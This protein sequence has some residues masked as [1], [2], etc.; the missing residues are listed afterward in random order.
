MGIGDAAALADAIAAAA[1]AGGDIGSEAALR[2]YATAQYARNT[3][4]L[5]GLDAVKRLFQSDIA[6]TPLHHWP[7][8]RGLGLHAVN[9]MTPLK[10]ALASIAMGEDAGAGLPGLRDL[11]GGRTPMSPP[12]PVA[13][14]SSVV[15]AVQQAGR[16]AA[17][18]SGAAR[19]A[20]ATARGSLAAAA[21]EAAP[22]D[23][24][25]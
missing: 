4:V 13:V 1:S 7:A 19:D 5:L 25:R 23:A 17:A 22:S 24:S 2:P 3:G 8:F 11:V 18:L 9:A 20:A 12:D 6:G 14:V 10:S 16:H 15:Q 21:A